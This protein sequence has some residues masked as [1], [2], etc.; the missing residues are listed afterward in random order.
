MCETCHLDKSCYRPQ[1]KVMF[2]HV[3]V[4]QWLG[5]SFQKGGSLPEGGLCLVGFSLQTEGVPGGRPS[6][7]E[8]TPGTDI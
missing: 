6:W 7:T 8:T 4:C 1:G 2:S 3:S 5:V